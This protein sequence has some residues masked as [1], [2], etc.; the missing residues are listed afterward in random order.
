MTIA[1]KFVAIL[2]AVLIAAPALALAQRSYSQLE[3]DR[4]LAP[5]AL[6]PDPL[7]SQLLMAATYPADVV[8]AARWSR[9]NPQLA[10]D[11]AVR[12]AAGQDWDPSVMSLLAFP[13][14]LQRMDENLAWTRSLGEAFLAQEPHVMETVQQLRRR[15]YAAGNLRSDDHI[16]VQ[17]EG[18]TLL[19][20][21]AQ[22]QVAYVPYYDPLVVYGPWW[23]PA[24]QPVYWA[25]WPGYVRA[26]RPGAS[27][28]FWWGAPV[29]LSLGFFFGD[30]DWRRHQ[31][32]VV[33]VRNHYLQTDRN[34][35]LEPGHWRRG[36][37]HDERRRDA[38]RYAT[39]PPA[40]PIEPIRARP[41]ARSMP[42]LERPQPGPVQ[43]PRREAPWVQA[44]PEPRSVPR[45]A[46]AAE[47]PRERPHARE[48]RQEPPR[49]Q[50]HMPAPRPESRGEARNERPRRGGER[51]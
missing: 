40:R 1:R 44:A 25:P 51:S 20:A 12:A 43:A 49:V 26:H 22:L 31:V 13:H 19:L 46:P 50:M 28:S 27:L 3:L 34:R 18:Q 42:Q 15:A 9:A 16:L 29:R 37:R 5:V 38:P 4:M 8:E 48:P 36:T 32:R 24:Y 10:G 39:W 33:Q 30:V 45:P 47:R 23:W 41:A 11:D 6:Y 21:P 14:L 17:A 2:F 7:L 35:H